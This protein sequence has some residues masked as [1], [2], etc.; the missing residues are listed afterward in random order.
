MKSVLDLLASLYSR[1]LRL[2][3]RRFQQEFA[4][5]MQV[6]FEDAMENAKRDGLLPLAALCLRELAGL[7]VNI[8]REF[9]DML[10]RKELTMITSEKIESVSVA[11]EGTS[12]WDAL[13]GILPFALFG[14]ASMVGKSNLPIHGNIPFIAV[15]LI[16]LTGLIFGA[17]T[18]FPRWSYGY[19]GWSVV[20]SWWLM[21]TPT[22]TFRNAYSPITHN[23]LLLGWWGWLPFLL[24]IGISLMAT[25]SLNPL[26]QLVAGIWQD[27]INL[28]LAIFAFVGFVLLIYD[29]NHSPYLI[30]FMTASTIVFTGSVWLFIRSTTTRKRF[31]ILVVGFLLAVALSW[32]CDLTWDWNAYYGIRPMPPEPWYTALKGYIVIT[33]LWCATMFW[34]ALIGLARRIIN[35][36][37]PGTTA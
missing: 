29:E 10:M 12:R 28:S 6:V 23:Q 4:E 21:G 8:L 27:W 26:R 1:L 9:R 20:Y 37:K 7:P 24:A 30:A 32:T 36:Q 15:F 5:E 13:V 22:D 31:I 14:I 16:T 19:L 17:V 3:P 18:G 33:A 34:P 25:R 2:Y 11:D 35:R